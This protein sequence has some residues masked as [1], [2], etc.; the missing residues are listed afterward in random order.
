MKTRDDALAR[1]AAD[2]L[3]GLK[4]QF[5]LP[6]GMIYLDGNSLGVLPKTTA[7]RVQEV[8][9]QEWGR[10]LI[11]AWNTADWMHLPERVGDKIARLVGAA[12][13]ELVV[14][15]STSLNL[16]KV[17]AAALEIVKTDAPQRRLIVSERS[18][19]PTDLYIAESLCRQHG[20]TL[21]LVDGV[22]EIPAALNAELAVLMLTEVNY[23]SGYKHDMKA[24]TAAAHA[25][26]ALTV[27]DL[28]HS[29]GAVPVDL[30]GANADFAIGCGYKYLNGGP[31]APAFVWVHPRHADRFWQPLSGWMG[32]AAP[33]QFT[34]DYRPAPG[35]RR[36]VC[37]TPSVIATSALECGVDTVLAAEPLG[38]MVAL[39][40]KSL[41]LTEAF[42]ALAEARCAELGIY[43]V[44]PREPAQRGSQVCLALKAPLQEAGY[45]VVQALIA[46][47]VIGDY[48]AGDPARLDAMPHILRFGFTP[49][50]IGFTEVWD[51]V[52]HLHQVLASGEWREARFN[53]KAAVT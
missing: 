13:G 28:A 5:D 37:G 15:D 9:T 18:N 17:L 14:A 23:R 4:A 24:L 43:V 10:D 2:P 47:G 1:D 50:Y 29:A 39:R 35:V 22:D 8:I 45:A 11:K 46:R 51:A 7:A 3:R 42:A 26:G 19:F 38:G 21:K 30:K 48:R 16:Y 27:W 20:F 34:P 6:P 33:F 44:S 40:E 31:G 52:E 49:L 53:Q 32:H 25:A 41:A 12:P 36:Y